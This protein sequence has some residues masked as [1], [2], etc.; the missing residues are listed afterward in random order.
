[1]QVVAAA[2]SSCS[3]FERPRQ[4]LQG[5]QRTRLR[6]SITCR[7][8]SPAACSSLNVCFFHGAYESDA[9]VHLVLELLSGGPLWDRYVDRSINIQSAM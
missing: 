6:V 4:R 5:S 3:G 1:M 2:R 7:C 9:A 8:L